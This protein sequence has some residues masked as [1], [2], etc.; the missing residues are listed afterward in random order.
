MASDL[1]E[2]W[3]ADLGINS[4]ILYNPLNLIMNQPRINHSLI[5]GTIT[6]LPANYMHHHPSYVSILDLAVV[7]SP[8]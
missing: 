1:G 3:R 6:N 4:F 7:A 8:G 5:S 2:A